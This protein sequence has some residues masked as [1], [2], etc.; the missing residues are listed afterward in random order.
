MEHREEEKD[1]GIFLKIKHNFKNFSK[2]EKLGKRTI[3]FNLKKICKIT[4]LIIKFLQIL[5]CSTK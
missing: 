2:M 1:D 5:K 3:I 4:V